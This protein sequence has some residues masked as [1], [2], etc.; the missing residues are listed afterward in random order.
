MNG[1]KYWKYGGAVIGLGLFGGLT[2]WLLC[3]IGKRVE[4]LQDEVLEL[5][6]WVDG[7]GQWGAVVFVLVYVLAVVLLV[8]GSALAIAAGLA[9][10]NRGLP[11][12]LV[13]AT[14]GA[15]IAFLISR[16]L[17]RNRVRAFTAN[18]TVL[19]A[20]ER[21]LSEGGIKAISLIRFSPI[22]P[23]NLQNY[24]FGITDVP[25]RLY[26][27]ATLIG[28]APGTT[29]DVLIAAGS[30]ASRNGSGHWLQVA[31]GALG[32]LISVLVGWLLAR[33]VKRRMQIAERE[34]TVHPA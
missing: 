4:M 20:V 17:A 10:G 16:H 3:P 28:I 30:V 1:R 26:L 6:R 13:A 2:W 24:L 23:F 31:F 14:M 29:A 15:S 5:Q 33:S 27:V 22:V 32:L 18:N 21:S 25:F 34:G 7:F 12:A 19:H 8:P 11:L 9:Y